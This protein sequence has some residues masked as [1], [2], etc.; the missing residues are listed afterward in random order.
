MGA[1]TNLSIIGCPNRS[2]LG[3]YTLDDCLGLKAPVF[4]E[5][6][7]IPSKEAK[8]ICLPS[9]R[10]QD[11]ADYWEKTEGQITERDEL[12]FERRVRNKAKAKAA[13]LL[14]KKEQT[15]KR[16]DAERRPE[17]VAVSGGVVDGLTDKDYGIRKEAE[18]NVSKY[19]RIR[20]REEGFAR[21]FFNG[22][23]VKPSD[24]TGKRKAGCALKVTVRN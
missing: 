22:Q 17:H 23:E 2:S 19:L 24:L 13:Y 20:Q 5:C 9:Y 10:H 7:A 4:L 11:T 16:E 18:D 3:H 12:L 6:D 14:R 8:R 21:K 15:A 1:D